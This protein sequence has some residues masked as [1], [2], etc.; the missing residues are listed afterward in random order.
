MH[1]RAREAQK[2]KQAVH[3]V[4]RGVGCVFLVLLTVGSFVLAGY[5][6]EKGYVAQLLRVNIP[7][8][9]YWTPVGG[10]HIPR[11]WIVQAGVAL[12]VDLLGFSVVT[13]IWAMLNPPKL[14]PTDAPPIQRK[15]K[16]KVR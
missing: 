2:D 15:I 8:G 13:M 9:G 12:A 6:F 11:I 3:P 4:W 14:G 1:S 16:S 7:L 10:V 5:L